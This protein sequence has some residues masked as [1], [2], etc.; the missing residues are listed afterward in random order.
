MRLAGIL[1][2]A[3]GLMLVPALLRAGTG[4][5]GMV[6][7]T[8]SVLEEPRA[9]FRIV[10]G[11]S[12]TSPR[13]WSGSLSVAGGTLHAVRAWHLD[14]GDA[15]TGPAAWKAS[16]RL[17]AARPRR[18][19][20]AHL[21]DRTDFWFNRPGLLVETGSDPGTEVRVHTAAG[22]FSFR[23]G[24]IPA[25]AEKAF[26]GT[27]ERPDVLVQRVPVVETLPADEGQSDYPALCAAADGSVWVSW[28]EYRDRADRLYVRRRASGAWG[29]RVPVAGAQ[30]DLY[31]SAV[32][33]DGKGRLW[34]VWAAQAD[35]NW[36]LWA[37]SLDRERWSGPQQL[38]SFVEPDFFP[39]LDAAKDGRLT[40]VWQG[41]RGGQSDILLRR[42]DGDRWSPELRVSSSSANDWEPALALGADGRAVVAW[43]THDRGNY[44]IASRTIGSGPQPSP[45][46]PIAR[47]TSGQSFEAHATVAID[48]SGRTWI[49]YDVS[50]PNWG[51]DTGFEWERHGNREGTRLYQSRAVEVQVNDGSGFRRI[52]SPDALLPNRFS[53]SNELP[54][55]AVDGG[56]Q[57]WLF[58]RHRTMKDISLRG[59]G[60][61]R[62]WEWYATSLSGDRWM[63]AVYLARSAGRNDMRIAAAPDRGGLLAVYA[64]DNRPWEAPAPGH[65]ELVAAALPDPP[66]R[67]AASPRFLVPPAE[68]EVTPVHPG[69]AGQVRRMRETAFRSGGQVYHVYRGDMHRHTDIS[70][71]GGGDGSLLDA[72]RYALDAAALDFLA[73][74]DHQAGDNNEYTWWRGQKLADLFH[75]PGRFTP[76]FAYERSLPFP[77]GHRN[78]VHPRR[79]IRP[80]PF[81][82]GEQQAQVNSGPVLYPHLRETGGIAMSHTSA[83]GM[84]TDWRDNDP[85]L[86]PLVEIFQGDRNN[87]EYEGA[88][89]SP[90]AAEPASQEGGFRP[91]GF[92]WN[93]LAKG[94]RLGFQAS[95][96][97]L[98]TH[99]SYS[100]ILATAPTR[101]A[102]LEGIRKRRAYGATDNILLDFRLRDGAAEHLMGEDAAVRSR[103]KL[104]IRIE[105]TGPLQ[106]V[107]IVRSNRIV[108]AGKPNGSS[109][110]LDYTDAEAQPGAAHYYYVRVLQQDGQTAWSSP[111]W[112]RW[113][114]GL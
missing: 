86:E 42:L 87:Y 70:S 29:E 78:V 83:T 106:E 108:F 95:S 20:E 38:T 11:A 74:T 105:G 51:K 71:D 45:L 111:I 19:F 59:I 100:C 55:L 21:R 112:T 76:L 47:V 57:V 102:L 65:H 99:L 44:D 90:T 50:G 85:T 33:V 1:V 67:L 48:G 2:A 103:P 40:L 6:R 109:Y 80:L 28:Q 36:D 41:F 84:G 61:G 56:G 110:R 68:P 96:D 92:V 23:A 46:G 88:P 25:G 89:H 24:E 52:S 34:V 79:G 104:R 81:A 82:P 66:G 27:G 30:G 49:G 53:E 62:M 77:N 5:A 91:A 18:P 32:A 26:L 16:S 15:L 58:M 63:P 9:Q 113:N 75:V 17:P 60:R 69:E 7:G 4:P 12:D 114:P 10:L 14:A 31:G 39:R 93:A 35:Q 98:S 101:E 13:D 64:T 94:Y 54:H 22:D 107:A 97:H 43:D 73:I 37:A 3:G 72:Y 8:P